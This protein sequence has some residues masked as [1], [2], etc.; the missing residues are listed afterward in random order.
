MALGY[1]DDN[2]EVLDKTPIEI[3]LGY[4][5]P[6]TL[7]ENIAQAIRN[8]DFNKANA[9][10][11]TFEESDD[12]EIEDKEEIDFNGQ[13][14]VKEMAPEWDTAP[15]EPQTKSDPKVEPKAGD[16]DASPQSAGSPSEAKKKV[17]Q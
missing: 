15:M 2:R 6:L 4:T 1:D 8:N 10:L 3:P 13:Y 16:E 17:A 11:E 7:D 14:D 5:A 9:E 12:F